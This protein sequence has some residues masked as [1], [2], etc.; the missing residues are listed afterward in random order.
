MKK[1][2]ITSFIFG[3]VITFS[4]IIVWFLIIRR[5][6]NSHEPPDP[7]KNRTFGRNSFVYS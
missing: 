7:K 6:D 1:E 3:F 2:N 5:I 4:V